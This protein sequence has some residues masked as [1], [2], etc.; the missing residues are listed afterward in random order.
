M[1]EIVLG[2]SD[3]SMTETWLVSHIHTFYS[4]NIQLNTCFKCTDQ[5][6][7]GND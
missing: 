3:V 4:G 6:S 5:P 1:D 7:L 2:Y